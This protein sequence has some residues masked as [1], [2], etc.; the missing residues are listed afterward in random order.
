VSI[1]RGA[2]GLGAVLAGLLAPQVAEATTVSRI[3]GTLVVRRD[4]IE[5]NRISI[6]A[7][8]TT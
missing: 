4:G 7:S 8:L 6:A 5:A 1:H 2:L 3:G